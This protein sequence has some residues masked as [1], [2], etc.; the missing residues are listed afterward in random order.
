MADFGAPVINPQGTNPAQQTLQT[1]SGILGIQQQKAQLQSQTAEAQQQQQTARQRAGIANWVQNFDPAK[2][3]A[4]DGTLDLD[5]VLTDPT[6][7][8]AAGDQFPAVVQSMIGVKSGQLANINALAGINNEVRTQLQQ[9]LGGIRTDPD[10]VADNPAGRQKADG[11][12]GQFA[13][14]SPT[15]AR[16][17]QIYGTTIDHAPAGKLAQVISNMQLQAQAAGQQSTAQAPSLVNTGPALVNVN[18]QS[19]QG[20]LAGLPG[21]RTGISPQIATTTDQFGNVRAFNVQN[22]GQT[23]LVG[24]GGQS[25]LPSAPPVLGAGEAD[26]IKANTQNVVTNRQQAQDALTQLDILNR[27]KTLAGSGVYTG[28]GSQNVAKLATAVSQV[29]GFEQASKYAQNYNE[30]AKFMAQNAARMGQQMGLS[31]SDSRIDLALHAQPNAAMDTKSIQHVSDYI[32]GLVRMQQSKAAAMD[33][34][35]QYPGHSMQNEDQFEHLWRQNADPRL[36]Q[37]NQMSD[38][39]EAINYARTH[40]SAS[41]RNA[42]AQKHDVLVRLGALPG[43]Q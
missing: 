25:E 30:L 31:G 38:Q 34:W 23:T 18:P 43:S 16:I 7:R 1:L 17:A 37:L 14:T 5:A 4:P 3:V 36:F 26:V 39:N 32:S 13:A 11:V 24:H 42:L 20:N 41:E 28:P 35:L 21:L 19:A 22:P 6:L 40:I 8:Q 12:L 29:P 15:A 27:I 9:Q 2:H 33:Q 10:V